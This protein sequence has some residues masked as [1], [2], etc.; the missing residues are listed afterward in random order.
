[1]NISAAVETIDSN[2]SSGCEATLGRNQPV[3]QLPSESGQRATS[4]NA[5]K[6]HF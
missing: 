5:G 4:S 1:M 6:S 3:G 2:S